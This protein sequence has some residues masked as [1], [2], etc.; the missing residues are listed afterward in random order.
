LFCFKGFLFEDFR[1]SVDL[2]NIASLALINTLGIL[3]I[4]YIARDNVLSLAFF[5]TSIRS[6]V[7]FSSFGYRVT[8][9][10]KTI[11]VIFG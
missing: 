9:R 11:I 6:Y 1:Y 5:I 7:S 4:F 2:V 8:K 10:N 3:G